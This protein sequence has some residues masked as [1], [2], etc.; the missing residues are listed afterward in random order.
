MIIVKGR[1]L[2]IPENERYI[3]TTYD[4]NSTVRTFRIPR[5]HEDG[6]DKSQL[7]FYVIINYD[8][9]SDPDAVGVTKSVSDDYIVLE[10]DV[11]EDITEHSGCL[12]L[13]VRGFDYTGAVRWSSFPGVF[14]IE[15]SGTEPSDLSDLEQRISEED[16]LL[17]LAKLYKSQPMTAATVAEMKYRNR[18]YVY[19][20]DEAGY[21]YGNWYFW[22]EDQMAWVPGGVYNSAG[23]ETDKTLTLEDFAAD[24]KVVGNKTKGYVTPQMYGAAGDGLTDDSAAVQAATNNGGIVWFPNGKYLVHGITTSK[25]LHWIGSEDAV[26]VPQYI[27]GIAQNIVKVQNTGEAEFENLT[28]KGTSHGV[29]DM[30]VHRQSAVEAVNLDC[31]HLK[32]VTFDAIDDS[33]VQWETMGYERRGVALTAH[34]VEHVV[35]DHVHF[36]NMGS[37]EINWIANQTK[38]IDDIRVDILNCSSANC[39]RLSLFDIFAHTINIDNF[40]SDETDNFQTYSWA[41]LFGK[42]IRVSRSVFNGSSYGNII[43]TYEMGA[44]KGEE[45]IVEKCILNNCRPVAIESAAKRIYISECTNNSVTLLDCN[46]IPASNQAVIDTSRPEDVY[47]TY[48]PCE[49][50]VITKCR[51]T[52]TLHS[53]SPSDSKGFLLY[54]NSGAADATIIIKDNYI[55]LNNV[56]GN[57]AFINAAKDFI[58]S[59]NTVINPLNTASSSGRKAAFEITGSV[60]CHNAIFESNFIDSCMIVLILSATVQKI[61]LDKNIVTNYDSNYADNIGTGY[62]VGEVESDTSKINLYSDNYARPRCDYYE[63]S[64]K[65][66]ASSANGTELT[67]RITVPPGVYIVSV[68][69]PVSSS[70]LLCGVTD[71]VSNVLVSPYTTFHNYGDLTTICAVS[72]TAELCVISASSYSVTFTNTSGAKIKAV[73][74]K[75]GL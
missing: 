65:A 10:W 19:V 32:N 74:I 57:A 38:S 11:G 27:N 72:D 45:L 24:A 56:R 30:S 62:K 22:D 46:N 41:N 3:G 54:C 14:Y 53:G 49:E 66:T 33:I 51:H 52:T 17:R 18:I 5:F 58:A 55:D 13:W 67:N 64:W 60:G 20:G 36:E 31:L 43:D 70:D 7:D 2:L 59:G 40:Y 42:Y 28:F 69:F 73:P 4:D 6:M 63:A 26:I 47:S 1:E 48:A 39:Y 71:M 75:F 25:N 61:R 44:W 23:I 50:I 12:F 68:S 29:T 35:F 9:G 37:D 16:K 34:D 21:T 15:G 8:D